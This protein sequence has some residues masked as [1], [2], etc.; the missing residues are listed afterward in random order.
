MKIKENNWFEGGKTKTGGETKLPGVA[1]D[2]ISDRK[3]TAPPKREKIASQRIK[4]LIS[5]LLNK[6]DGGCRDWHVPKES[7]SF[8]GLS[9]RVATGR[10][11]PFAP[12]KIIIIIN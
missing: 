6:T 9:T 10:L 12:P 8:A 11:L 2:S 4:V 3:T 1:A 5:P 7:T